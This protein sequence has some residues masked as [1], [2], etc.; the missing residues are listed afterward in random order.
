MVLVVAL[1]AGSAGAKEA[2]AREG[3]EERASAERSQKAGEAFLAENAAREG[4][5]A[6][7][8][9]LQYRILKAGDG[10]K[11]TLA[12]TVV[13]H[14]RGSLVDG[15]ELGS[16]YRS[17]KPG[18]FPLRAAIAG[19]REALQLMPAGSKWQLF[20]PPHLAYG[21]RGAGR[22]GP[23][24]TLV[25]EAELVSVVGGD[26]RPAPTAAALSRIEVSF[27]L[28]PRLT[29]SLY[30]GDR[31]VSPATFTPS[32]QGKTVTVE[33]SARGVDAG[34]RPVRIEPEWTPADPGMVQITKGRGNGADITVKRAGESTLEVAFRGI[35]K[36]LA[37]KASERDG[38]LAVEISQ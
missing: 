17:G 23:N 11:P 10:R 33:A 25:F 29:R 24:A 27:K 35:T 2:P 20:V 38:A 15:T 30:M 37:V 34:G 22:I 4:V 12:D 16:S 32:R 13:V 3:D 6:L 19:W 18:A 31:W 14:Y 9:G 7:K 36:R 5:V 21:E 8:S 28:D 26:A 1:L